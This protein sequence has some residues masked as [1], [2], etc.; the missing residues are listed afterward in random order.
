MKKDNFYR[1]PCIELTKDQLRALLRRAVDHQDDAAPTSR[2]VR[3]E[4]RVENSWSPAICLA[5]GSV[6]VL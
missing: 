5:G 1:P 3:H 6:Q 2:A 4:G